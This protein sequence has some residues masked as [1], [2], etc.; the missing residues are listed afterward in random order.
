MTATTIAASEVPKIYGDGVIFQ[1][2]LSPFF[3][4]EFSVDGRR[5]RESTRTHDPEK[6]LKYLRARKRQ[7]AAGEFVSTHDRKRYVS[8]LLDALKVNF[9]IREKDSPQNLSNIKR[10]RADFGHFRALKLTKEQIEIYKAKRLKDGS[11][12]ASINR[13]LQLLKQAYKFAKLPAP[14]ITKLSECG[15]ARQGF[16]VESEIRAVIANLPADL[17]DFV[18]FAYCVGMRR[19]E[20]RSLAWSSVDGFTIRL[21]AEDSKTGEARVIPMVGE[22]AELLERRRA[23]RQVEIDK[24]PMLASLIFHRSGEPIGDIRKAWATACKKAGVVRLFHDLRRSA[25]KNMLAAGVPQTYAMRI[26]G[27]KTDSM[28]RRYA[29]SDEETLRAALLRTQEH[30]KTVVENGASV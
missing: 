20:I 8:D 24:V 2:P 30:Q 4:C 13:V 1:H 28:F 10:A 6:A 25:C 14:E 17:K 18:L 26:S 5:F 22:L 29:I 9:E 19:S 16:F 15:N 12:K 11:A 27:H 21:R 23:A 7:V 3:H